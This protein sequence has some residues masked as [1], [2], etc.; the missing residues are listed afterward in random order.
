[1]R[2]AERYLQD[3]RIALTGLVAAFIFAVQMLNFP[4]ASGTSGH[5]LGGAL[6]AVLVGPWLGIL[7]VS[8]VLIVQSLIFADGGIVAL[9]A[10]VL[11]VAVVTTV[12]GWLSFRSLVKA[13]PRSWTTVMV[14]TFS[15]ALL[16]VVCAALAFVVEY[17]I[18]GRGAAPIGAVSM[19]MTGVHFLIGIG[20][21]LISA[22]AVAAVGAARPDLIAGLDG[23]GIPG[24][25]RRTL[26]SGAWG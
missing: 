18:G 20:E 23:V 11:N 19:A 22:A 2:K 26:R 7:A 9:G 16:A 24:S 6:A 3:K 17:A 4:V 25:G 12:V 8:V 1:M 10:N 15:A 14:A 13:L 21:G 5:L